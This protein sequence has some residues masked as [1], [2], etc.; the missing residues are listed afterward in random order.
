MG[1]LL[2]YSG[3]AAKVR[4]MESQFLTDSDFQEMA[5]L[6]SV[7]EAQEFLNVFPPMKSF[8]PTLTANCIGGISK[9]SCIC[10]YTGISRGF[11]CSPLQCSAGF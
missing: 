7:R 4:A 5:S 1:N 8:S 11:I 6:P 10:P 3:I 9:S 2:T